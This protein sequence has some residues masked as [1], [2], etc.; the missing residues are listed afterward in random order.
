VAELGEQAQSAASIPA[1]TQLVA[2]AWLRWHMFVN[3]FMRRQT[4]TRKTGS[5]V[6]MVLLRVLLWPIFAM[7]AIGPAFAAGFFAWSTIHSHHP[8]GLATLLA[9]IAMLWQFIAINGVNIAAT[10]SNFD[11]A[12][13]L[14]F[15][16]RFGRY[17]I[18]RL[19]LGLLIPSTIIGCLAL[20]AVTA[21]IA[22]AD[23]SLLF[24]ALIVLPVY[25][26]MNIFLARL[27]AAWM[28]RWMATRRAR[29]IFGVLMVLTIAAFQFFNFHH[30]SSHSDP[31]ANS[32]LLNF[33][34][35][36][37]QSLNWLPPGFAASSILMQHHPLARL[38]QFTALIACSVIFLAAFASRLRRQFLGEY[39]SEGA[40]PA[41]VVKTPRPPVATTPVATITPAAE[42]RRSI[43]SPILA[44]CLRKEWIYLRNSGTQLA[45]L[46]MPLVFVFIFSRG[47]LAKHPSFLI[48]G[49]VGYALMGPMASLY[50][51]FGA[52]GAGV[53]LYL[54]APIRLRD[55]VIAKNVA[56]ITMLLLQAALAW[57]IVWAVTSSPI[58]LPV[59]VASGFWLI[60]F[61][62]VNAAVGTVRSIQAPRKVVPGQIRRLRAPTANRTSGL[63]VLAVLLG[64]ILL[65]IPVIL[66]S[67]RLHLPWL[68]V[69][70][71]L[72]LAVAAIAMHL[73]LLGNTDRMIQEHR[74]LFA[75][76]L[77]GD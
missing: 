10:M 63:M 48:T 19:L 41:A 51:V 38:A 39:L 65:Q 50:N 32:W 43:L 75:Q 68:G 25:A 20:L 70:I 16:L 11:P 40:A 72:P 36:S 12:S 35:T 55:V 9:G 61:L 14:R 77:C 21:G 7:M 46:L 18:L 4:G 56:G 54:L 60:F 53:Q 2:I 37:Y 26:A 57:S 52:D 66:V 76:E 45:G 59:Q 34:R 8:L 23:P 74:D 42:P 44:A 3:G 69:Y 71:F 73:W 1:A 15:P 13:L 64:S 58:P 47:I 6:T 31:G 28:E 27:I 49:A 67:H 5:I 22:I 17:L 24:P 33:L 29:E 30:A 62:F